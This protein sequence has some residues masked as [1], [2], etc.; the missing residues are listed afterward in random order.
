MKILWQFGNRYE[1][2]PM[3]FLRKTKPK[4]KPK[5]QRWSPIYFTFKSRLPVNI[6][7]KGVEAEFWVTFVWLGSITNNIY[8]KYTYWIVIGHSILKY[9][10]LKC[11]VIKFDVLLLTWATIMGWGGGEG[12]VG[13]FDKPNVEVMS[14][15]RFN[16]KREREKCHSSNIRTWPW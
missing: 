12:V 5:Q 9:N 15:W 14:I 11:L 1:F 10:I 7:M 3:C 6:H 4:P 2:L 13:P 16:F 8:Y